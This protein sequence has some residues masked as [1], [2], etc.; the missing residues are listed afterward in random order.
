MDPLKRAVRALAVLALAAVL[1]GSIAG[2]KG[3]PEYGSEEYRKM[4]PASADPQ[5]FGKANEA[6]QWKD[7]ALREAW[8]SALKRLQVRDVRRS[9]PWDQSDCERIDRAEI[10]IGMDSDQLTVSWG[11]PTR[12]NRTV[13]TFGTNE[14]WVYGDS[15]YVYLDNGKVTSF[16][17]SR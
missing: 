10:W 8:I 13:G 1:V 11:P 16:Q 14:Q 9:R 15:R 12:I 7:A 3:A 4:F 5:R 17:D 2:C 6:Q